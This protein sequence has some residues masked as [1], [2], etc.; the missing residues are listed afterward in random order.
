MNR[1]YFREKRGQSVQDGSLGEPQWNLLQPQ[2][3]KKIA[4]VGVSRGAGATFVAVSLAFLLGRSKIVEKSQNMTA[5]NQ[6]YER[7]KEQEGCLAAYM[8][9]RPPAAG[10]PLVYYAAG[11]DQRFRGQNVWKDRNRSLN[12]HRGINWKV[13]KAPGDSCREP[14]PNPDAA[15]GRWI[16]ADSPPL[17]SLHCYDLVIGVINPLPAAVFAGAETYE[18]LRDLEVSGLSVLW[19]VNQ[20]NP[21]VNHGELTRFLK[22]K[23]YMALPLVDGELFFQA[24]YTCRLPAEL[25]KGEAKEKLEELAERVRSRI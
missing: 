8:E 12:L 15:E 11:L 18:I 7:K 17:E 10:E 20:D 1:I 14:A 6:F 2:K 4:V 24:Q 13:W 5:N 22:L 23:D 19:V 16:V 3:K 9:M 25:M 21:S